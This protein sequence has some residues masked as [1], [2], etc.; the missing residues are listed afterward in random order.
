MFSPSD[1]VLAE[2]D[3]D[4]PLSE[5]VAVANIVTRIL[6]LKLIDSEY[7]LHSIKK[8]ECVKGWNARFNALVQLVFSSKE[9]FKL[10]D[11][12]HKVELAFL[13]LKSLAKYDPKVEGALNIQKWSYLRDTVFQYLN[14][15]KVMQEV[16]ENDNS[17]QAKYT[18][19]LL[20]KNQPRPG[21]FK[22]VRAGGVIGIAL[23][24]F[25]YPLYT[26]GLLTAASTLFIGASVG[27]GIGMTAMAL[28]AGCDHLRPHR[29]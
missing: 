7:D 29:P 24:V 6:E 5:N 15:P 9:D 12:K 4:T 13:F 2:A 14:S 18:E 27:A 16:I 20:I 1:P 26:A 25:A 17:L 3:S 11:N 10:V 22:E 21:F 23:G 8:D 28:K 19:F